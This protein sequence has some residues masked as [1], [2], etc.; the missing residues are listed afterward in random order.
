[1]FPALRSRRFLLESESPDQSRLR[2][3]RKSEGRPLALNAFQKKIDCRAP[4]TWERNDVMAILS[5]QCFENMKL[6]S[7]TGRFKGEKVAATVRDAVVRIVIG[8]EPQGGPWK[9]SAPPCDHRVDLLRLGP[10][11]VDPA[12]REVK[13]AAKCRRSLPGKCHREKAPS[14][15]PTDHEAF[16]VNVS[17]REQVIQHAIDVYQRSLDARKR[18]LGNIGISRPIGRESLVVQPVR[19]STAAPLREHNHPAAIVEKPCQRR[20]GHG[21]GEQRRIVSKTRRAMIEDQRREGARSG[22]FERHHLKRDF[23]SKFEQLSRHAFADSLPFSAW[24]RQDAGG[25]AAIDRT[26]QNF[27]DV[28]IPHPKLKDRTVCQAAYQFGPLNPGLRSLAESPLDVGGTHPHEA[29]FVP[30]E[31]LDHQPQVAAAT[32]AGPSRPFAGPGRDRGW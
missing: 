19:L 6:T 11:I 5:R 29:G 32:L 13:D 1:M 17:S 26:P 7:T 20:A 30:G 21:A 24:P 9:R 8:V 12:A 28:G 3:V 23:S 31:A 10:L 2:L 18:M 4:Q 16:A 22:R 25:P 14:R 27:N 15:M